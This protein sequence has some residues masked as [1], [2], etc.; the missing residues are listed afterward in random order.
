LILARPS[1]VG[2]F[3]AVTVVELNLTTVVYWLGLSASA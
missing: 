2:S 1:V 3:C